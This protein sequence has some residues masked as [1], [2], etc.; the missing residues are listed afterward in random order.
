MAYR[1]VH[2]GTGNV[3]HVDCVTREPLP[4]DWRRPYGPVDL[5][6]RIEVEGDVTY[7]L[8]LAMDEGGSTLCAMPC[9]NWSRNAAARSS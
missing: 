6:Y 3:E 4:N 5:A 9:I 1:V 8:E 7:S 2:C